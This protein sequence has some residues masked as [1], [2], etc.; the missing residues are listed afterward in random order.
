MFAALIES[1]KE[2]FMTIPIRKGEEEKC[3]CNI[4]RTKQISEQVWI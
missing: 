1:T 4:T 2:A 3:T